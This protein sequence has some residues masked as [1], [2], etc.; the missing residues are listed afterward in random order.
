MADDHDRTIPA[1]PRRREAAHRAGLGAPADL[2]AW[3]ASVAT[4]IVL[5]PAWARATIPAAAESFRVA[6]AAAP[7]GGAPG[8]VPWPLSAAV[9]APTVGLVLAAVAAGLAVRF[10]CEGPIWLP[11]RAA[12]DLRRIDP[13][14]GV[15]RIFSRRTLAT[16]VQSAAAV[17]IVLAAA[18]VVARP[19]VA[20][21]AVAV[22]P[23]EIGAVAAAG[24]WATAWIAATAAAV[25]T[26]QWLLARRGFERQIRMTP[27]EFAEERKELQADPRVRM[28]TRDWERRQPA[29][30]GTS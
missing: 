25:G 20:V 16:L 4:V 23:D 15:Q 29:T 30:A 24:W 26:A 22:S 10:V 17:V 6:C 3:A 14:A 1:T 12:P 19:L 27:Q 21:Q 13:W 11:S 18:A 7:G 5:A 9:L 8:H 28:R 2:P